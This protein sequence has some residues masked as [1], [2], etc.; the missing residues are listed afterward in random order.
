MYYTNWWAGTGAVA[1]GIRY[2][3]GEVVQSICCLSDGRALKYIAREKWHVI[4][5]IMYVFA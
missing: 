1:S 2:D 3:L 5:L 4:P